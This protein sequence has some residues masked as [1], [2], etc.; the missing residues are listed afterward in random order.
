MMAEQDLHHKT[1][2]I[3]T[4]IHS[5]HISKKKKQADNEQINKKH[6]KHH[7]IVVTT[8]NKSTKN[9]QKNKMTF[10]YHQ[11]L[12]ILNKISCRSIIIITVG[13]IIAISVEHTKKYKSHLCMLLIFAIKKN[14]FSIPVILLSSLFLMYLRAKKIHE[15]LNMY[16]VQQLLVMWVL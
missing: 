1:Y 15:S 10:K 9:Q 6:W 2:S 12:N 3:V 5:T 14:P 7:N 8:N 16:T 11:Y 4:H 13:I